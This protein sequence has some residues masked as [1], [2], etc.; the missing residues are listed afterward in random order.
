MSLLLN[1]RPVI[2]WWPG[3]FWI[4][5]GRRWV[6]K[7]MSGKVFRSFWV[8]WRNSI[9]LV[10]P[11]AEQRKHRGMSAASEA[12]TSALPGLLQNKKATDYSWPW[13]S[14][15]TVTSIIS[16]QEESWGQIWTATSHFVN[17]L[18][19]CRQKKTSVIKYNI[20]KPGKLLDF[21]SK[22]HSWDFIYTYKYILLQM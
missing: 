15:A 18:I 17:F 13:F 11:H 10:T 8:D 4:I 20:P 14:S 12:F 22:Y 3:C 2:G 19:E 21:K 5:D 7:E 1:V 6:S 9:V 16:H